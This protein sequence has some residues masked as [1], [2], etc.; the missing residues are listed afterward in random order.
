[1]VHLAVDRAELAHPTALPEQG[2]RIELV[3][4]AVSD[5]RALAS[6]RRSRPP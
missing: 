5:E 4:A 2:A 6:I 3:S 1:M